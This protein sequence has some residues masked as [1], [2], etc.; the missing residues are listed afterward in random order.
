[1]KQL[2]HIAIF[3]IAGMAVACTDDEITGGS[4][5]VEVI[6][7][8]VTA[9]SLSNISAGVLSLPDID[10]TATVQVTATPDNAENAGNYVFISSDAK[11]F[12]VDQAGVVTATGYGEATLRVVSQNDA[13]VSTSCRVI[14][15]GTPIE[16]IT[17]TPAYENYT[18]TRTNAA[19]PIVILAPQI[20]VNPSNASVKTLKYTSSDLSVALVSGDGD[21]FALWEGETVIRAEAIDG[22]G[23]FVECHLTVNITPVASITFNNITFNNVA[24]AI[25]TG[26]T[27]GTLH[28]NDVSNA[29]NATEGQSF[30]I[31]KVTGTTAH[32]MRYQPTNASLNT[33][34][35]TSS[36]ENVMTVA[37][38]ASN[39]LVVTPKTGVAGSATVSIDAA[40]GHG[41]HAEL[42]V[43]LHKAL[44]RSAWSI[45]GASP[46]GVYDYSA[47]DHWGGPVENIIR[48][49]VSAGLVKND[50]YNNSPQGI[51]ETYFVIDMAQPTSFDYVYIALHDWVTPNN[52]IKINRFT[53]A[54][55]NDNVSYTPLS[56]EGSAGTFT[57]PTNI[58]NV[59]Y[60]LTRPYSY[61]YLRVVVWNTQT[62]AAYKNI[63]YWLVKDFKLGIGPQ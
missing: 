37:T 57:V 42:N 32:N 62:S 35:Y 63:P 26:S 4:A 59:G 30:T 12:T 43:I 14:V 27:S 53:L 51:A 24:N 17:I 2:Y 31:P 10:A 58:Y 33:F 19:G 52:Y 46:G 47:N 45:A 61:R 29:V 11:V 8:P 44:D 28:A 9:I 13:A 22:S 25:T 54:G 38:N 15:V 7:N 48:D 21:I 6:G 41:A 50:T 60:L 34:T 1:M 23:K 16:S 56:S 36:D 49:G 20:T 5:A 40:D 55:S 3:L 39:A 18:V